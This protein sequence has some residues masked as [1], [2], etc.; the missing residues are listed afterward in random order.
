MSVNKDVENMYRKDAEKQKKNQKK[1]KKNN[2]IALIL[3]LLIVAAVLFLMK[4]LGIGFG[5]GEGG[6]GGEEKSPDKGVAAQTS[7]PADE[8]KAM[9][10][11]TDESSEAETV[12]YVDITVAGSAFIYNNNV[13]EL[14]VFMETVDK[15]NEK[16]VVRITDDNATQNAMEDLEKALDEKGRSYILNDRFSTPASGIV[17]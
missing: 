1:K 3:L 10:E 16:V 13:T 6:S 11:V 2:L 9:P 17:Q 8:A 5:F 7:A 4:Y 15:M 14:E 12:E